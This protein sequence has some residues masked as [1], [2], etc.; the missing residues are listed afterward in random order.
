MG[1]KVKSAL[2]ISLVLCSV[3]SFSKDIDLGAILEM[4]QARLFFNSNL[5]SGILESDGSVVS[6]KLDYDW[7]IF[8]WNEKSRTDPWK[9]GDKGQILVPEKTSI[10]LIGFFERK[11]EEKETKPRVQ[12]IIIDP[13]H[14][15]I[16]PGAHYTYKINGSKKELSEKDITLQIALILDSMLKDNYPDKK[17]ILTRTADEYKKLEERVETAN[18]MKPGKHEA[19][20]YISI[21][22]NAAFNR[23]ARGFQVWYLPDNYRRSLIDEKNVKAEEKEILP[24]L[25]TMLEEEYTVESVSLAREIIIGLNSSISDDSKN[26][27]LKAESWFVV[28]NAK[29]P[30]VLIETGFLSNEGEALELTDPTYLKKVALGIYNGL[31]KFIFQFEHTK[32]FTE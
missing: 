30:S 2:I 31:S 3:T 18:S 27:G 5:G 1:M 16:D 19:V 20:I 13:G 23:N 12:A 22:V 26:L 6:F 25:N 11:R 8:D 21:H 9:R 14:G 24:I 4:T 29:M 10:E 17:T 15:G 28:R 7:M 32:G